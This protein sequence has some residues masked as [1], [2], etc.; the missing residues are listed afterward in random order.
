MSAP[1]DSM[2][3]SHLAPQTECLML[4]KLL[5]RY[6]WTYKWWLLGVLVFQF[7]SIGR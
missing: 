6:L 2:N 1:G 5:V 3:R 7:A 4:G